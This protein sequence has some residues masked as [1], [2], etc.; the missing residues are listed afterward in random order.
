MCFNWFGDF[1]VSYDFFSPKSDEISVPK[2]QMLYLTQ[3]YRFSNCEC[4]HAVF[5]LCLSM[6]RPFAVQT[7]AAHGT[8]YI[9]T[10]PALQPGSRLC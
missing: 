5:F 10:L 3:I 2:A 9:S 6:N 7:Q 4:Q 1:A 8:G